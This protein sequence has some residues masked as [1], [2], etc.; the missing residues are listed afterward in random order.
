MYAFRL[1]TN[2]IQG[3]IIALKSTMLASKYNILGHPE[4]CTLNLAILSGAKFALLSSRMVHTYVI[5]LLSS[6]Q[7]E[8]QISAPN[9]SF[10]CC[11]A[12][13]LLQS[14]L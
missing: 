7:A 4:F 3:I 1:P 5:Y 14:F 11:G 2:L 8:K 13:F 10:Y 12:G 9:F 6:H